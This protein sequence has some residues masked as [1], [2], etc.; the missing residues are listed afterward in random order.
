MKTFKRIILIVIAFAAFISLSGFAFKIPF[1]NKDDD[2]PKEEKID[3][4][5]KAVTSV[6]YSSGSDSNWSYGTL[7]KE[8][9]R[10]E[11]CYLRAGSTVIAEKNR[12]VD[13]EITITY[14]FIGAKNCKVELSD[15]IAKEEETDDPNVQV[16]TRIVKAQKEKKATES[17]VIFQYTPDE[18]AEDME[19]KITY[20]EHVPEG[21]DAFSKIYFKDY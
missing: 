17:V 18:Q 11:A 2:K 6:S 4:N 16:Y 12:G 8:F 21:S 5:F 9:P 10:N 15:G 13:E 7:R 3:T 14:T 20:D 1:F 19:L